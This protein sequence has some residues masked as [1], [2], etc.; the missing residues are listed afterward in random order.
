MNE[1]YYLQQQIIVLH[2]CPISLEAF[3]DAVDS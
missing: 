2:G 1:K 3:D